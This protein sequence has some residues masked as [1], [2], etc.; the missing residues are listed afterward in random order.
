M[1]SLE[2]GGKTVAVDMAAVYQGSYVVLLGGTDPEFRGVAKAMNM[3]HL[4]FACEQRLSRVDFLCGDF[5]WK[6]LW[7]LDPQPLY[8]YVSPALK[9]EETTVEEISSE[10]D[11]VHPLSETGF[12]AH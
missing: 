1:I 3:Q 12:A 8:K 7:H 2:I 9:T 4:D 11:Y 6:K 10:T 5:H